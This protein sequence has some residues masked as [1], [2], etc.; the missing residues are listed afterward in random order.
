MGDKNE[1]SR[2]LSFICAVD[3]NNYIVEIRIAQTGDTIK[4]YIE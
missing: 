4:W 1:E 3:T 2:N